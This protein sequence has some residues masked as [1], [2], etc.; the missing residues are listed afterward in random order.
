MVPPKH[1][2]FREGALKKYTER[3]EPDVLLRLVAPPTF[4]FLWILLFLFLC[5][6]VLAWSIHV[7]TYSIGQGILV[8]Q[9]NSQQNSHQLEAALFVPA[10]QYASL[11]K[12]QFVKLSIGPSALS[13][14]GVIDTVD[15]RV[16]S[17]QEARSRFNLQGQLAQLVTGP[18]VVVFVRLASV[19][20]ANSYAGSVCSAQIQIGSQS[21]LSL[22][23]GFN[24][25]FT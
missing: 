7:P 5:A 24:A 2:I 16:I 18:A 8:E 23:P 1:A 10:G 9:G 4:L 17:P 12:G 15:T 14:N 3:R 6:G 19:A 13:L 25:I 20:S 22:L 11:H 21:I